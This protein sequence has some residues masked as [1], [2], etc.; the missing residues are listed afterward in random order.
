[1]GATMRSARVLLGS[2]GLVAVCC[3][4]A[5][6]AEAVA[7]AAGVWVEVSPSTIEPGLGISVRADCGENTSTATVA[8]KAFRTLTLQPR[9]GL[10]KGETTVPLTTRAG[11][12][13]V[14]LTCSSGATASTTLSVVKG[15]APASSI[16]PH[17][18]GGFLAGTDSDGTGG[19]GDPSSIRGR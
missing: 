16:G 15:G 17:T 4:G 11:T 12:Y 1:M 13:G 7:N 10:L 9:G 6:C 14:L 3:L 2:T 19:A 8:S 18:G 5:G